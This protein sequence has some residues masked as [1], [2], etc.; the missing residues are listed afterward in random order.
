[1]HTGLTEHR[2][3]KTNDVELWKKRP[4]SSYICHAVYSVGPNPWEW[5][6]MHIFSYAIEIRFKF[7]HCWTTDPLVY[8]FVHSCMHHRWVY[9]F[10][11]SWITSVC[12]NLSPCK[13]CYNIAS[14][15]KFF[16]GV[17]ILYDWTNI[18][19]FCVCG[20]ISDRIKHHC[21]QLE[22]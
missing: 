9:I 12:T 18:Y 22:F 1:M 4:V 19:V 15:Y 5:I 20:S 3:N 14:S 17:Q 6:A 10:V 13:G 16:Q 2:A 8:Q 21:C 11:Q 7:V